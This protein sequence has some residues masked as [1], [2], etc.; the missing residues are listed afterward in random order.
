MAETAQGPGTDRYN[1]SAF[2]EK[3][4]LTCRFCN[5]SFSSAQQL[6]RHKSERQHK[7]AAFEILKQN[8]KFENRTIVQHRPP[9]DGI[10]LGRYKL[11]NR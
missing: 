5:I 9:P 1:V 11:C 4:E 2:F 8:P 10:Y 3:E 7:I 6:Q